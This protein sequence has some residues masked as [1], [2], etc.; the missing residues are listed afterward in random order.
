MKIRLM[1]CLYFN[2][3][4]KTIIS[5][6]IQVLNHVKDNKQKFCHFVVSDGSGISMELVSLLIVTA[7]SVFIADKF[8]AE[9][10]LILSYVR[11]PA[12]DKSK[13]KIKHIAAYIRMFYAGLKII[14]FH[15]YGS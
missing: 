5:E 15:L 13:D 2:L 1:T 3:W 4:L 14:I 10:S 7:Y 12:S 11:T 6:K 9:L 8:P